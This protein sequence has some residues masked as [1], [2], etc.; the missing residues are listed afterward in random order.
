MKKMITITIAAMLLTIGVVHAQQ[1]C[2]PGDP[3]HTPTPGACSAFGSSLAAAKLS[4]ASQCS[5][6]RRD[7]DPSAGGWTCSSAQIGNASPGNPAPR[8]P[9]NGGGTGGGTGGSGSDSGGSGGSGGSTGGT[10]GGGGGTTGGGSGGTFVHVSTGGSYPA[11]SVRGHTGVRAG[12]ADSY[13]A[14]GECWISSTFDHGAGN[15]VV[16]TPAGR[17]TVRELARRMGP[18]PG[19]GNNPVYNDVQCG[20]GPAN[21]AGD[22][23]RNVCPGRVDQGVA[24]CRVFGPTWNLPR[25]FGTAGGGGGGD[26]VASGLRFEAEDIQ[27]NGNWQVRA[28]D[29][30]YV[31][32]NRFANSSQR[33]DANGSF[34]VAVPAAGTYRLRMRLKSENGQPA[35]AEPAND[36]WIRV[37]TAPFAKMFIAKNTVVDTFREGGSLDAKHGGTIQ[38]QA[39]AASQRLRVEISG[40]SQG[41]VLDWVELVPAGSGGGGTPNAGA[42]TADDLISIQ[43][44][45]FPDW[46]DLMAIVANAH[47]LDRENTPAEVMTVI[48][49]VRHDQDQVRNRFAEIARLVTRGEALNALEGQPVVERVATA[50]ELTLRGGGTVHV[51]DGGPMH[52]TSNVLRELQS[53]GVS[54]LKRVRVVQHSV[55]A[56]QGWTRQVDLNLIRNVATYI[57]I[58]DGNTPNA[59]PDYNT[60]ADVSAAGNFEARAYA[61]RYGQ[62][63][64]MAFQTAR[65]IDRPPAKRIVDFSDSVELLHILRVPTSAAPTVLTWANRYL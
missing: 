34:E 8:P 19:R 60:G 55:G 44:D 27:W 56:N 30:K 32:P 35:N 5:A 20:R 52:F 61:S 31:G 21:N 48:G 39:Q 45:G 40:R 57:T 12:W 37:G 24:G 10:T 58:Q 62:A 18:G 65:E 43:Y 54:N 23:D 50:W 33:D 42:P 38:Y 46:D 59:T 4:Y 25:I 51:A 29:A 6:P 36:I 64:R 2:V 9:S 26:P 3:G 47:I 49:T 14:G 16:N 13:S 28:N 41:S 7:C 15:L 1:E 53:R 63:W 11:A 17:M 22:E